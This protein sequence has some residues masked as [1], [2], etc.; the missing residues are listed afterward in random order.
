[1]FRLSRLEGVS[2]REIATRLNLSEKSIE[3]HL[4]KSLKIVR[5]ALRDFTVILAMFMF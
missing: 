4:T 1:V 3:Y 5:L 2:N